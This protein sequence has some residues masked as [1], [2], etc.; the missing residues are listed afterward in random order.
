MRGRGSPVAAGTAACARV[1]GDRLRVF[2]FAVYSPS[3]VSYIPPLQAEG[4]PPIVERF[5][6]ALKWMS[7]P[8]WESLS[9]PWSLDR[10]SSGS[11]LQAAL[12]SRARESE[13]AV[14]GAAIA[15]APPHISGGSGWGAV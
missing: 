14:A 11:L 1:P 15:G 13:E 8:Q 2:T 12:R 5:A 3:F 7:A 4:L 6:N 10:E 9:R